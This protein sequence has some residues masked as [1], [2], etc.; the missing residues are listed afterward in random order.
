M[1]IPS[2]SERIQAVRWDGKRLS[3]LDQTRLPRE[4]VWLSLTGAR[5]TAEAIA[6]LAVRGAPNIGIAAAYGLA[7]ELSA[8]PSLGALEEGADVLIAS[9]PTAVNL[10]WAVERVR[11]AV[12]SAGP[13]TI[14]S[15]ARGEAQRIQAAEDAASEALAGFGADLL[16]G[17]RTVLTHCNTGALATGGR[18][19][20]LGVCVALAERHEG[21]KVIACETRPLLQGARLTA[22]ELARL[23]IPH[24]VVVDGAAA[25]LLRRGLADAV[26][27]GCDR[28]AANGDTANKVGTYSHALA[29]R[30]AG[31]PFVVAG[32]TSTIDPSTVDGDAIEIEERGADEVTSFGGVSVAPAGT[33]V[34][35]PAFDVT[36]AGLVSALVTERG[37]ASPVDGASVAALLAGADA[38]A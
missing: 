6:R 24:A 34:I 21:V 15:A 13:T 9:R 10:A 33:P 35:N 11:A 3:I 25:S 38:V 14:S 37:V 16:D 28:V 19:S 7:M 1:A 26:I 8:R 20:A 5:D 29:A 4:E 27:V 31:V 23:G 22:W 17:A 2:A 32:P 18:G 12:M 36:P 30:A